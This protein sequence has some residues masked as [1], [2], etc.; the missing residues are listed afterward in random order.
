MKRSS[1]CPHSDLFLIMPIDLAISAITQELDILKLKIQ[2]AAQNPS[3]IDDRQELN[4]Y[5]NTLLRDL[6]VV[7]RGLPPL[8]QEM[9]RFDADRHQLDSFDFTS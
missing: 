3:F 4:F 7:N 1:T 5:L 2:H 8:P 6:N 9:E